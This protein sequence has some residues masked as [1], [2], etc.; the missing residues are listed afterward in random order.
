MP[1]DRLA[2]AIRVSG[3]DQSVGLLGGIGDLAHA[4]LL[5]AIQLP[6]HLEAL[7]GADR[8]VLGR[9]IADVTIAGQN[10]VVLA[11]ILLDGLG[12]GRGSDDD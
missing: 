10:L 9:Q 8:A 3:Q 5:V 11:Q 1:A 4:R 7:V 12:L 6:V 2:L